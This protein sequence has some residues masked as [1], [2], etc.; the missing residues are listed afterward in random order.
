MLRTWEARHGFPVPQR[1]AGGHRWYGEGDVELVQRVVH[2][3]QAGVRLDAAIREVTASAGGTSLSVFGTLRKEHPELHPQQLHKAT[4]LALSRAIEDDYLASGDVGVLCAA[5]QRDEF[6][7]ASARRW[8]ELARRSRFSVAFADFPSL[9]QQADDRPALVP[10]SGD[11]PL[12]REWTLVA[13]TPRA[14]VCLA[15]WERPGG[16]AASDGRRLFEVVWT[17]DPRVVRTALR[18]CVEVAAVAGLSNARELALDDLP[19][20]PTADPVRASALFNRA[21]SYSD[22]AHFG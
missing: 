10:L 7:R 17:V 1:S 11:A 2:R 4:V 19:A 9:E 3:Q 8:S 14:S 6:Y 12:R 20:V 15:A 5:F 21:I 13:E 22:R 16:R 18:V